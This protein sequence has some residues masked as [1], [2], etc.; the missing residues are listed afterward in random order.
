[1]QPITNQYEGDEKGLPWYRVT[2]KNG[3]PFL[4]GGRRR[5]INI[6]W[7]KEDCSID[8]L[9]LDKF[10]D[11]EDYVHANGYSDTVEQL[12]TLRTGFGL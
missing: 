11:Y 12:D 6:S 5:V 8:F 7:L 10:S 2:T 3:K 4:I 9:G 1:M